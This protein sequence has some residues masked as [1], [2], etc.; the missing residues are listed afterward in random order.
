MAAS[1]TAASGGGAG[2]PQRSL[3][4]MFDPEVVEEMRRQFNAADKDGNGQLDAEEAC[5][6]FA[7]HCCP[8]GAGE[9]EVQ[10]TA[11]SLFHQI[12]TDRSG[13]LS[14]DEY[15]FR[16][17]RR[18]QMEAAR[19]RRSGLSGD[20][21]KPDLSE[22]GAA[23]AVDHSAGVPPA[24][25]HG[26]DST[27][28]ATAGAA[29]SGSGSAPPTDERTSGRPAET[30]SPTSGGNSSA[31]IAVGTLVMLEGLRGTP[32]LNG[33]RGKVLR[34][35]A[36]AGRYVV[37]VE[38]GVGPKSLRPE[39]LKVGGWSAGS[40]DSGPFAGAS[41]TAR[42]WAEQAK[43]GLQKACAYVQVMLAEYEWWQIA[44][45][46]AVVV[47][48]AMT[49]FQVQ[50]RYQ[51]GGGSSSTRSQT[52]TRSGPR[53]RYSDDRWDGA[54]GAGR[55]DSNRRWE[56]EGGSYGEYHNGG[57]GRGGREYHREQHD[58][59]GGDD[60]YPDRGHGREPRGR[61]GAG[62]G[63]GGRYYYHEQYDD[64]E[65]RGYR[66]S[67]G[68]GGLFGDWGQ[69]HTLVVLGG[70]GY[71]CYK[72]I[73]PV[74]RMSWFQIYMLWNM[75]EPLLLGGRGRGFAGGFGRR[76]RGFF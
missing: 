6:L 36:A 67:A 69:L 64:Y 65:D 73:I 35:D 21:D 12:D 26:A 49:Y 20:S 11:S 29:G 34:F 56:D 25:Q 3:G 24:T 31:R 19:R 2:T 58:D 51:S 15:C 44:L 14:F 10:R 72:G 22:G 60:D 66:R 8:E 30:P 7:R 57:P 50:G 5:Q 4:G 68:G 41:A 52:H 59:Y 47:L 33:K 76:Q 62:P 70:L 43:D 13:T 54:S 63:G 55:T 38:G 39:N 28:G 40:E 71:L 9:D 42:R 17:G 37:E 32:Q 23:P 74:H 45:G 16:F 53:S 61:R 75:L 48:F 18:Y 27:S 46:A 1:G